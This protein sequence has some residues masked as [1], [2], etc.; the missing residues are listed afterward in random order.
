[1][2]GANFFKN[3]DFEIVGSLDSFYDA[4]LLFAHSN[5][6]VFA[7][8]IDIL[9]NYGKVILALYVALAVFVIIV[10]I[11]ALQPSSFQRS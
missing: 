1:M 7:N 5:A 2:R 9:L 10:L 3:E 8:G 4:P 6:E 11:I